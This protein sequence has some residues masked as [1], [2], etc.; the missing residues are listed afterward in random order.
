M[1]RYNPREIET[2]WQKVWAET[3][4]YKTDMTRTADKFYIIPMLPYP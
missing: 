1:R 2:K 4:L 3:S